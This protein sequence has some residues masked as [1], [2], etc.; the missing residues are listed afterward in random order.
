[1]KTTHLPFG[2]T[3]LLALSTRS[4]GK[5][6]QYPVMPRGTSIKKAKAASKANLSAQTKWGEKH[7]IVSTFPKD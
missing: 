3:A 5:D 2:I 4:G 1:M 7:I 6:T